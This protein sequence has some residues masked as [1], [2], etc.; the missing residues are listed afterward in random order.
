MVNLESF[1]LSKKQMKKISGGSHSVVCDISDYG[2][3]LDNPKW[4]PSRGQVEYE[5]IPDSMDLGDV[6]D[7]L[8]G[9]IG[10]NFEIIC[11]Y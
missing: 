6:A 10:D 11:H 7:M 9:Q 1:K 5:E 3:E 8:Y 2:Y 4:K